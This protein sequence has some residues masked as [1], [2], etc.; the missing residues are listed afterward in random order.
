M[1]IKDRIIRILEEQ[2]MTYQQLI[3]ELNSNDF[4]QK[5]TEKDLD[6]AIEK[7]NN[8]ILEKVSKC[9]RIPLYSFHKNPDETESLIEKKFYDQNIWKY[10]ENKNKKE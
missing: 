4:N 7:L 9:L 5:L 8:T 2:S 10:D 3:D 1:T 6:T